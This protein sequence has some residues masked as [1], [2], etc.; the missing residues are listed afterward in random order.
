[1]QRSQASSWPGPK[2]GG[3]WP[4]CSGLACTKR[5]RVGQPDRQIQWQWRPVS[6]R[7]AS[8]TSL[9]VSAYAR[10]RQM[11]RELVSRLVSG[12]IYCMRLGSLAVKFAS[13]TLVDGWFGCLLLQ[14]LLTVC[15]ETRSTKTPTETMPDSDRS[16]DKTAREKKN[17]RLPPLI[18]NGGESMVV[19]ILGQ[20]GSN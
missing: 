18:Q 17:G 9:V 10:Q 13:A 20:Q 1:M 5:H 2:G 19:T 16:N 7:L 8:V 6:T 11:H 3:H 4:G 15:W 12:G 14:L